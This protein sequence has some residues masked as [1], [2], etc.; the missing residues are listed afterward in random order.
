MFQAAVVA[1]ERVGIQPKGE[2]WSHENLQA[3]FATELIQRRKLYPH[4][5]AHFLPDGLS[6]RHQADYH[7]RFVSETNARRI[8]R[9]SREFLSMIGRQST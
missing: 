9:W 4:R 8:L 3:A 1:L 5:V 2:G 7:D 6:L